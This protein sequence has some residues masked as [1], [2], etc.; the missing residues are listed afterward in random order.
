LRQNAADSHLLISKNELEVLALYKEV[1][2]QYQLGLKV[3]DD[4][5]LLL[6]D[7]NHGSL[8]RVLNS[9]EQKRSGRGGVSLPLPMTLPGKHVLYTTITDTG[10]LVGLLPFRIRRS[11]AK[12]QVVEQQLA[13]QSV[14]SA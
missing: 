1:L 8:R 9:D 3:P 6:A 7:D 11:S 10:S 5:T 14:A 13:I 4:I 12:L 2:T